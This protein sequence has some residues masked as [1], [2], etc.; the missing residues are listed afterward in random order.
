MQDFDKAKQLFFAGLRELEQGRAGEAEHCFRGS[1][2]LVPNRVSTLVNLSSS[3]LRQRRCAEAGEVA[4]QVLAID[5][6]AMDGWLNLGL[7]CQGMGDLKQA[8]ECLDR[9]LQIKPDYAEALS[10]KGVILTEMQRIDEALECHARGL[11]FNPGNPQALTNMGVTLTAMGRFDEAMH[12][13]DQALAV[14]P[15]LPDANWNQALIRLARGDFTDG[16]RQYE[17]RWTRSDADPYLHPEIP[18]LQN[19]ALANGKR[20]LVWAEQGL[21][22][23]LQFS[24]YLAPLTARGA[25]V[26]FEVPESLRGLLGRMPHGAQVVARDRAAGRFDWQLPLL[27][28]PRLFATQPTTIPPITPGLS[29]PADRVAFWGAWFGSTTAKPR[30]GVA[31]RGNPRHRND[32]ARSMPLAKLQALAEIGEV[33]LIQTELSD[34]DRKFLALHSGIRF[35]GDRLDDFDETAAILHHMDVVVSVDTSLAHLAGAMGKKLFVLLPWIAEWRWRHAGD[36]TPW[37]DSARLLRQPAAGDWDSVMSDLVAR[38]KAP[39]NC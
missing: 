33:Y 7:A 14:S 17:Y 18:P 3:L 21:G 28:L 38:L 35:L 19:L 39:T 37:Y 2:A 4:Q 11:Q 6:E 10:D 32:L 13:Y 16:W 15:G 34:A 26:T 25:L 31:V 23:T 8:L 5:R 1:L 29:A 20:V 9:A 12:C 27:S 22:D 24:R 36:T 30:I